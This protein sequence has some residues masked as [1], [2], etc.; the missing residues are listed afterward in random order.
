MYLMDCQIWTW[1]KEWGKGWEM[2]LDNDVFFSDIAKEWSSITLQPLALL[3]QTF[4]ILFGFMI[5]IRFKENGGEGRIF[6]TLW[7]LPWR[8]Y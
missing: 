4:S 2:F 5:D 3:V 8:V 1:N 6:W 7:A